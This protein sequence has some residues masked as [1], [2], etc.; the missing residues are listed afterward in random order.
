MS[1]TSLTDDLSSLLPFLTDCRRHIHRRPEEG[2]TEFETTWFIHEMLSEMGYRT[3]VG[4]EVVEPDAA[5]G[6]NLDL[7]DKAQQRALSQGVPQAFL[8]RCAGWTGVVADLNTKRPGPLTV[9]R[10]EIDCVVVEESHE[11]GHRP[12]DEGFASTCPGLMH[13]CGH[14]I[15]TAT[16]LTIARWCMAHR[17]DLKGTIRFV[18]QPAE[19]GVRGARAMV[20]KGWAR[21]ADYLW[22]QH[23]TTSI[24][25]N[26]IF[27]SRSGFLATAKLNVTFKGS[28][29][30]GDAVTAAANAALQMLA[31]PRHPEGASRICVGTLNAKGAHAT[32]QTEVRGATQNVADYMEEGV[33]RATKSCA[34]MV[35]VTSEVTLAGRAEALIPCPVAYDMIERVAKTIPNVTVTDNR[36]RGSDDSTLWMNAVVQEGGIAGCFHYGARG[37][38]GLHT[39]YFDADGEDVTLP[40]LILTARLI[41]ETNRKGLS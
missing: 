22:T 18:F 31:L 4:I 5:M 26:E 34:D 10:F 15:H 9:L 13:S 12:F 20:A 16:G 3:K 27:A 14:D 36:T 6:R 17:D 33:R 19:E 2:W 38:H 35:G 28:T 40:A 1:A 39:A 11:V 24:K 8:D 37:R 29:P 30:Y 41:L 32:M 21:Q 23:I 7:V 25:E